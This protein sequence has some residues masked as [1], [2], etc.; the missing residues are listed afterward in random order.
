[1]KI[2]LGPLLIVAGAA[3]G[4]TAYGAYL[5]MPRHTVMVG[6]VK[7]RVHQVTI[8][9]PSV[10]SVQEKS[11]RATAANYKDAIRQNL[12]IPLQVA[13]YGDVTV[14]VRFDGEPAPAG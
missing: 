11:A 1:M 6:K 7:P 4:L 8:G 14:T 9:T 12:A 10:S 5:V 3:V 2:Y 13:G